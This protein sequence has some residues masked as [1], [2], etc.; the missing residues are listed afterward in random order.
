ATDCPNDGFYTVRN[1]ST[2]CFSNTWHSLI[3]D[4]TGNGN[5]YFMLVNASLQPSAFYLD[6]VRGLC[7][8]TQYEFAAW[9]MN[10]I[11][12]SS[13]NGNTNQPNLTFTIERIDGTVLQTYNSGNIPP[14]SS[15]Q[16][17][18]YG[19]F[20]TTP[21]GVAD[22]VLR[23]VNN[24]PGGCGNDLALDD[25]TFRPCGA[26][27]TPAITGQSS[28][29]SQI[30][31]GTA[32]SV[33]LTCSVGP[34]FNNP[35][36]QWQQLIANSWTDIPAANATTYTANFPA[37]A[38]AGTYRY[39]LTVAEAGNFGSPQCRISSL[40]LTVVVNDLPVAAA[41][42]SGPACANATLTLSASGGIQ[43][44]WSGVNGFASNE[45]S[46]VLP[47]V[48]PSQSGMYIVQVANATGC[49]ATAST[50]VV[51]HPAPLAT[52]GAATVA[53][54]MGDS[55][56]LSAAGGLTYRWAPASGLSNSAIANPKASPAENITYQVEVTDVNGC[57]DSAETIVQVIDR[58]IANAGPDHTI[59][60][61][62]GVKLLGSIS[63]NYQSFAWTPATAFANPQQLQPTVTPAAD[64]VYRLTV[65]S[66]NGCGTSFDEV[67]VKLYKGIFIP[68]AFTPNN[69]G[70]NDRW[71]IAALDAFPNFEL[72]VFNRYGEV[73]FKNS[74]NN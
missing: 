49:V 4:H 50:S 12:P 55:V 42:N 13:C 71:N 64:A 19:F 41:S 8:N 24:A 3:S 31:T 11:L 21:A 23:I 65:T 38:L 69:D 10:V 30:C 14:A 46:P 18:Q 33:T 39:R 56:Q 54:C 68:S 59:V 15:P 7:G 16:W 47:A 22:V 6:T 58:A 43:Y 20:F 61:G 5:G 70:I 57:K 53:V 37:A 48:Q 67:A 52:T 36:Y 32:R 17:K 66:N 45:A 35:V 44:S 51:V 34:G 25:I 40:P 27:L 73:V 1:N 72:Y 29:T 9:V 60:G 2:G 28:N 63:G 62:G 74:G 26:L